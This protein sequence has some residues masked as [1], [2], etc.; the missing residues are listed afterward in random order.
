MSSTRYAL[1]IGTG[2]IAI[3]LLAVFDVIPASIAQMLPLAIVPFIV[4]RRP[5]PC[6]M[7]EC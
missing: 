4:R 2:A 1:M 5:S 3:A 6:A 7:R